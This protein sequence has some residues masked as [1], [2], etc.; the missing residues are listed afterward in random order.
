[1][2]RVGAQTAAPIDMKMCTLIH[3]DTGVINVTL[4]FLS[5]VLGGCKGGHKIRSEGCLDLHSC[6]T[7]G[8]RGSS[9]VA[10]V[11]RRVDF[12]SSLL[13]HLPL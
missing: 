11:T 13:H 12:A 1:M 3:I 2:F 8:R 9:Q 10:C 5:I 4:F 6:S 7:G